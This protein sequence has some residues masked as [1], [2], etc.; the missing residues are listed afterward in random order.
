MY[1]N[2]SNFEIV[3]INTKIFHFFDKTIT[4]FNTKLIPLLYKHLNTGWILSE[5]VTNAWLHE[6][7][8]T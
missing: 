1:I 4:A 2:S 7:L 3:L 5:D 6:A 8:A